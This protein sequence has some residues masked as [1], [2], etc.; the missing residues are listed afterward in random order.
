MARPRRLPAFDYVGPNRYFITTCTHERRP[1]LTNE[2]VAQLVLLQFL[3]VA[4]DECMAI[5]AYC[6]MPDHIHLL[7]EGTRPDARL[8]AFI[9]LA[10]QHSGFAF[11]QR[12]RAQLWQAGYY[13]HVLRGD[14]STPAI[15]AYIVN[16]PLRRGLVEHPAEYPFW[17]SSVYSREEILEFIGARRV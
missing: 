15:V 5:V 8:T 9:K 1:Y 2:A 14:E 11:K 16:N 7:V 6:L 10:K 12:Y 13:E 17:G 4:E 3:R